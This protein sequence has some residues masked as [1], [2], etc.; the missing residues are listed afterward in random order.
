MVFKVK[1]KAQTNYY[2]KIIGW[3]DQRPFIPVTVN[4]EGVKQEI[5]YNWPY[6]FFS[7]VELAKIE[8]EVEFSERLKKTDQQNRDTVVPK[9]NNKLILS[10]TI[11]NQQTKVLSRQNL[12]TS[13]LSSRELRTINDTGEER[14]T[15]NL[16]VNRVNITP[17]EDY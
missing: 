13:D 14:Q 7:L 17:G 5:S 12:R 15:S 1:Q 10:P 3:Q 16:R 9:V 2:E 8:A 6:D 4:P 11:R